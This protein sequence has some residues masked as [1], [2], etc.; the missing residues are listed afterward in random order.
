V[1][2]KKRD[3]DRVG[4]PIRPFL[5]TLDQIATILSVSEVHV[6][7]AYIYFDGRSI[8]IKDK[9]QMRAI[10]I[11]PP[12]QKPDWRVSQKELVDWLN[13]KGF[14]IYEMGTIIG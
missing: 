12:N 11:A 10:D 8:G 13:F 9:S 4:L 2:P 14:L 1:P 3:A 6:K 7:S 5:Y